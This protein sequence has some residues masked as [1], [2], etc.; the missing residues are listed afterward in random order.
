MI[1]KDYRITVTI[2]NNIVYKKREAL[3]LTQSQIADAIGISVNVYQQIE[4]LSPYCLRK[5]GA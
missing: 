2:K 3:S 4:S 5:N 1:N